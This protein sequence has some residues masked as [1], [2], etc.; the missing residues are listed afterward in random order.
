MIPAKT[1]NDCQDPNRNPDHNPCIDFGA[2]ITA[3]FIADAVVQAAGAIM[4]VRGFVG[5]DMLIRN[6]T[7]QATLVPGPVGS[8]GYGAWLTGRF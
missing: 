5:R 1:K 2:F 6:E 4:V 8:T 7:V 3:F